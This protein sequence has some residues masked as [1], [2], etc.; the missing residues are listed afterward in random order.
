MTV[1]GNGGTDTLNIE[2]QGPV[3]P[4]TYHLT[5]TTLTRTSAG[6]ITYGTVEAVH[7]TAGSGNDPF[8]VDSPIS[9]A[10]TVNLGGG[11]NTLTGPNADRIWTINA[12]NGGTLGNNL[13]FSNAQNLTG[14]L[15]ADTFKFVGAGGSVSGIISGGG[16]S[17]DS[18]DYSGNGGG[19]VS[20]NLATGA[21][22]S[23]GGISGISSLVGS[24]GSGNTLTGPST[25]NAW[26]IT[27][28]NAGTVNA[29]TYSNF[30]KLVGGVAWTS[31]SSATSARS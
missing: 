9:V 29:V 22:T 7:I 5:A 19:T 16:G 2:D 1:N 20:V 15:G 18:L 14:N 3:S 10:T 17:S 12:L 28:A 31:S 4:H 24:T 27:A 23:T 8:F 11:T 26:S 6:T 13:T 21:A 30:S 25:T